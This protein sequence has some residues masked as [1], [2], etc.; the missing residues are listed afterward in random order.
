[1]ILKPPGGAVVSTQVTK[2][3]TMK[4]ENTSFGLL[5]AII[6][7]GIIAACIPSSEARNASSENSG[8]AAL[9]AYVASAADT[10]TI[11]SGECGVSTADEV[12][13]EMSPDA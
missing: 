4:N 11:Y 1:M 13:T 10:G 2:F 6:L 5:T 7:A 9:T 8:L 3:K 12:A